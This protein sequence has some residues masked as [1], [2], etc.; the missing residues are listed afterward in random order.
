MADVIVLEHE[1]PRL[2]LLGWF[3]RDSGVDVDCVSMAAE[4]P[5]ALT[6]G[7]RALIINSLAPAATLAAILEALH[8]PQDLRVIVLRSG[9]HSP[10]EPMVNAHLCVHDAG[11]LDYLVQTIAAVLADRAEGGARPRAE[12]TADRP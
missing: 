1:Q 2:R 7:T 5:S 4:L 8:R 6:N 11:D 9:R 3:L 10:D 12:Q